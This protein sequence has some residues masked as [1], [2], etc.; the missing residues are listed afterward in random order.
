M[1]GELGRPK[2]CCRLDQIGYPIL[3]VAQKT[4]MEFQ[5]LTYAFLRSLHQQDMKTGAK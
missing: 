4:I 1:I 5:F 3:L 2:K